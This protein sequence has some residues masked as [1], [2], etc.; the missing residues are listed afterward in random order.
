MAI[1][2]GS[3]DFVSGDILTSSQY[4]TT[5]NT[6]NKLAIEDNSRVVSPSSPAP[7]GISNGHW[8]LAPTV[9]NYINYTG[10]G[11]ILLP[12]VFVYSSTTSS[13]SVYPLSFTSTED[14]E[15]V[16]YT[17]Y[18]AHNAGEDFV[19]YKNTTSP[20]PSYTVAFIYKCIVNTV[21]GESPENTP[22]KWE[23]IG[24]YFSP[25]L[26]ER[27]IALEQSGGEV[28]ESHIADLNNPHQTTKAQVGL[29]NVDNTT[30]LAKPISTAT[31]NALS[32]K[33]NVGHT[34]VEAD[35]LDLKDYAVATHNHA[36][37]YEPAN[38][39]IQSH[40]ART[41][42][43]FQQSNIS[44][45]K[46]QIYDL[47]DV[48]YVEE[49]PVFTASPANQ[50]TSADITKLGNLS[51][52]NS[53]DQDLSGYSQ[54]GH[55]HP[56]LYEPANANIQ[57][58]IAATNAHGTTSAV[59]GIS[60]LQTLSNKS[61]TAP[62][63]T[64]Y[65]RF[66][67]VAKPTHA[68]G[69]L[70][71][72]SAEDAL[73][74]YNS[75]AGLSNQIGREIWARVYNN[76]GNLIPNGHAVAIVGAFSGVS[77]VDFADSKDYNKSRVIGVTT[78]EIPSGSYGYVTFFGRV[79]D[80]DTAAYTPGTI[81]YLNTTSPGHYN[82]EIPTGGEYKVRIGR[83]VVQD[84]TAGAIEVHVG[85]SEYTVETVSERGFPDKSLLTLTW[86]DASRTL[87][88]TPVGSE[89]RFYQSGELYRVSTTKT[90]QIANTEGSHF[91][92]FNNGELNDLINGTQVQI[93]NLIRNYVPVAYI[94][95]DITNNIAVFKGIELHW[96]KGYGVENHIKDH[97]T[98][99]A[100]YS[101]GLGLTDI[102]LS[103][104]GSLASHAQFGCASGTI[105][106]EDIKHTIP[107][108]T[109]T[110]GVSRILYR[111]ASLQPRF[112]TNTGYSVLTTGTGRLAYNPVTGGLVECPDNT[113][114]WYHV[115]A[116]GGLISSESLCTMP[117]VLSYTSTSLAYSGLSADVINTQ[118]LG[119]PSPEFKLVASVLFQTRDVYTNAVNA[120]IVP[121]DTAGASFVDW[122][123]EKLTGGTGTSGSGSITTPTFSDAEFQIYDNVD[124]TKAARFQ[125]SDITTATTRLYTFP[126]K[127]GT[128][129]LTSDL[130][131]ASGHTIQDTTTTYPSR[132]N[133]K[134][135]GGLAVSDDSI[136]DATVIT[137]GD[138]LKSVYD[139][140][141]NGIVDKAASINRT[142]YFQTSVAK[143][144]PVYIT[145]PSATQVMVAKA[146]ASDPSKMPA[147]AVATAAYNA[148]ATGEVV[149]IGGIADLNT[150]S[151]APNQYLYVGTSGGYTD[152][153]PTSNIQ[154][155]GR[156]ARIG[157]SDGIISIN[158]Q[159]IIESD[160]TISNTTAWDGTSYAIP[161]SKDAV[162]RRT[163]NS[164][165]SSLTL[166][167]AFPSDATNISRRVVV[168]ID[169]SSNAT[170]ISSITFTGGTWRWDLGVQPTGLAA[171]AIAVL[172]IFNT[173][174]TLIKPNW[175]VEA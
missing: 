134:F 135:V 165:V 62:Y 65:I 126:D 107:A 59:V 167:L 132:A 156:V 18:T 90:L 97:T 89:Y 11:E 151:Y 81:L 172:E 175:T 94:Y 8:V 98:E 82:S 121:A 138:M 85:H 160:T 25:D 63:I 23:R 155:I 1:A 110:V 145:T 141:N 47:G 73:S 148:G 174:G 61:L 96:S 109:S 38:S 166:S 122:R 118:T 130:A 146:M 123:R 76:T 92:Y 10:V 36:G 131:N 68:Q 125:A 35:I 116:S 60:D 120:R 113:Y 114:V 32:T 158:I 78:M 44:I 157:G 14:I 169:N 127:D 21:A 72:D 16:N 49:D 143:G 17:D 50:I 99:G 54:I 164:S 66:A 104:N 58:H 139:V 149:A 88:V 9:G 46:D 91:I 75:V 24:L 171:G 173:S 64:N 39:N 13:W 152:V 53:G 170:A 29:G 22:M 77:T 112:S 57:A 45:S 31:Q 12:S 74:Y 27:V 20:N 142:V 136:N 150:S 140:D 4:N 34:H 41:D 26:E 86:S 108:M 144:D 111:N 19:Y 6:A 84:S 133:L 93:E 79:N 28:C 43:H 105:Y 40:I 37:V 115:F 129:A 87:S 56:G 5:H 3:V 161:L 147:F 69:I 51:G 168:I 153:K 70:Y 124:S 67:P 83:V 128:I 15:L 30:D 48:T 117:G 154:V 42:I 71:Y 101:S 137:G 162:I 100:R 106:D 80:L 163:V 102:I 52:V 95:W 55:V 103:G 33:S 159:P 119:L 7:T 2:P